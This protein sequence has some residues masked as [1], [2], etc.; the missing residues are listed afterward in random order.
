MMH[1]KILKKIHAASR[2]ALSHLCKFHFFS[3]SGK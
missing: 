2:R 1:F 3:D